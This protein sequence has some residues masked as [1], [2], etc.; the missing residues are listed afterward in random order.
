MLKI[1]VF[2]KSFCESVSQELFLIILKN[3]ATQISTTARPHPIMAP[4]WKVIVEDIQVQLAIF[5]PF[6]RFAAKPHPS[7]DKAKDP[8]RSR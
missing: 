5:L 8:A 7:P 3:K 4:C 1:H 2:A 6:K